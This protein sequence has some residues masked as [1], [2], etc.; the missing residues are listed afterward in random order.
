MADL[1]LAVA[2]DPGAAARAIAAAGG[3]HAFELSAEFATWRVVDRDGGWQVDVSGLRGG[4]IEADLA[5]RD[6]TVG[7]IAVPLAGGEPVDPLGGLA[8]LERGVLRVVGDGQLRRRPAAPAARRRGSAPSSASRS[9]R[10]PSSWPAAK[11]PA[12]PRP[13]ASASWSSCAS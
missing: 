1:D 4:S 10:R 11:R 5:E 3:G 9:I 13:P 7:A 6:F 2:G 8:D 12:P